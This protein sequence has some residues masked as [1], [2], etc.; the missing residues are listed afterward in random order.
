[1]KD[2]PVILVVDDEPQNIE[3]LEAYLAPQGYEIVKAANGEEALGKISDNQI[4]LIL[5]DMIMPRMSG[6]EVLE[7][8]RADK[9][10][11]L[12]PVVMVTALN[13]TEDRII[14]IECFR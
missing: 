12:I 1:L 3:L 2:K 11:R 4:D 14:P 5:L 8:L 10:T 13:E 9:K 7:K 6:L